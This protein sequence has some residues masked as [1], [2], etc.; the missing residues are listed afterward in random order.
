MPT[1]DKI[2]ESHVV[3]LLMT[4]DSGGGKTAALASLARAGYH[5]KIH[6]W[7]NGLDI[8]LDPKVLEPE[9]RKNVDAITL[10]DKFKG[11]SQ[12]PT[13][14]APTAFKEGMRSLSSWDGG[15][16]SWGSDTIYV[17]DSLTMMGDATLRYIL[18]MNG[19]LNP[20]DKPYQSDWGEAMKKQE[21]FLQMLY[22]SDVKCHVIINCHVKSQ[23]EKEK[24]EKGQDIEVNVKGYPMALG[25]Q[26]PP[27]VGRYF[28]NIFYIESSGTGSGTRR[29]IFT[30]TRPQI[31]LKNSRPSIVK[32]RYGVENGLA[33]IFEALT[34]KKSPA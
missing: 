19:R 24:D 29:T 8:L 17:C 31:E 2:Q 5:L 33:E 4:G 18:Y 11:T 14:S 20:M 1:L 28:N 26:L 6:D 9:Y 34:G 7:D 22:S 30:Q 15:I 32:D 10:T 21:E 27:K 3:K 13:A 12:G 25:R 16:S 23:G